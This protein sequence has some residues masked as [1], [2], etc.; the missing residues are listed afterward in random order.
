MSSEL[1]KTLEQAMTQNQTQTVEENGT[2]MSYRQFIDAAGNHVQ[3]LS[4]FEKIGILCRSELNTALALFACMEAGVTAI[5]MSP[6]YGERYNNGIVGQIRLSYCFT[7]I[8]GKLEL[9]KVAEEQPETEDL[10][11]IAVILCTSGTTGKPKGAMISN[12]N[13]ISNL[14]DISVYFRINEQDSIYI[15]RPL[16]HC[17]AFTG[18]FLI[19]LL[20]GSRIVFNS[21]GFDPAGILRDIRE[22]QITVMGMTPTVAR[23]LCSRALKTGTTIPL[24]I[25]VVSGECMTAE[26]ASAMTQA[27]PGTEIY[28]V[29]G[30]TE[31][32]PRV[33]Y[34][35][36]Y[37]FVEMPLSVGRALDSIRTVI[38]DGELWVSGPNVIQ[39]YYNGDAICRKGCY[40][41]YNWLRTGD[42]AQIANGGFITV[43]GR[44]D[45][46]IIR[47]GMNIYPREVERYLREIT[48][49]TDALVYGRNTVLCKLVIDDA[50]NS[51]QVLD[52]CGR[53]L[54]PHLR[55]DSIA[56]VD[57]L[58]NT[59]SGKTVRRVAI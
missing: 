16:M 5:P 53:L 44:K 57:K 35:P 54:P 26:T 9:C 30:L 39:K 14:S 12:E 45:D 36:P 42:M 34:L 23:H 6:R 28:H 20:K 22:K 11:D 21:G 13:L 4:R 37:L 24:R 7:D 2:V 56:I 47:A 43:L 17:A 8:N 51:V 38:V 59:V 50:A 49:V 18:E 1:Y 25:T 41:N 46:M 19:G 55:P 27:M 32:S 40:P 58:S 15:T 48:G 3:S 29:Y 52:D 31:A 33:T 10:T